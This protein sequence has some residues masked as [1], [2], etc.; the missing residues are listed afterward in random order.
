MATRKTK[1]GI[2]VVEHEKPKRRRRKKSDPD[3]PKYSYKDKPI[4]PGSK[5]KRRPP[6]SELPK[7]E[8]LAGLTAGPPVKIRCHR[9]LVEGGDILG[10]YERW[11]RPGDNNLYRTRKDAQHRNRRGRARRRR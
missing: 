4:T 7:L 6:A 8:H 11:R 2:E 9:H 3:I 1:S 10:T 5:A